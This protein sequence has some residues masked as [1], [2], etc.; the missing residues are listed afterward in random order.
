MKFEG[1]EII[2]INRNWIFDLTEFIGYK[3]WTH[4]D[5]IVKY[6]KA[7]RIRDP[8]N[9]GKFDIT[10]YIDTVPLGVIRKSQ[11]VIR[12]Y[13]REALICESVDS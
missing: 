13:Y 7:F 6:K 9:D 8:K 11:E 1:H 5:Q 4:K 10:K 2:K 3:V 12:N